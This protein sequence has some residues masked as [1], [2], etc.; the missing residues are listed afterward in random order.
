MRKASHAELDELIGDLA[1]LAR[2][3]GQTMTDASAALWQA[4]LPLAESIITGRSDITDALCQDIDHRCVRLLALQAPVA[5]DLRIVIAAIDA[6]SD[7]RRMGKLAQHIAKI[8]RLK[9]PFA[10]LPEDLERIFARMALLATTLAHD[11]AQAIE[12]RHP[13]CAQQLISIQ[14]EVGALHRQIF[15]RL[16]AKDW[17]H[18]VEPAVDAALIG[19]YYAR[20][21]DHATAI[22]HQADI[23]IT[24][25]PTHP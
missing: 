9:H 3:V 15:Q 12:N 22:A 17:S 10:R 11:T 14:E 1:R 21:T 24:G 16:F 13:H 23:I 19:R 7:V 8:A 20:F 5:T 25:L 2:R 6:V 4:D 18:G